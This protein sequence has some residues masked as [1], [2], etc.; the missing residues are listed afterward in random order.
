[1]RIEILDLDINN[2]SSVYS[3]IQSSCKAEDRISIVRNLHES[4]SPD[5]IVLPGLGHFGAGMAKLKSKELDSLIN[6]HINEDKKIVGICLGMQLLCEEIEEAPGIQ[7]LAAVK[8]RIRRIPAKVKSPHIGWNSVSDESENNRLLSLRSGKDFYFVHSYYAD[9][10][11]TRETL[12]TTPL[13]DFEFCSSYLSKNI[14]G[15]QF[16]PEKSGRVGRS[17]IS[18]LI[19]WARVDETS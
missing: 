19:E 17:L 18:E 7:G 1:M 4:S 8:G 11:D 12:T 5:L 9:L 10:F 6:R 2:L 14:L 15:F 16:H 3:S 13:A